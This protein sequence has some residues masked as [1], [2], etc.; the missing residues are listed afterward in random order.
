MLET[1]KESIRLLIAGVR[2]KTI[3]KLYIAGNNMEIIKGNLL[4]SNE[5]T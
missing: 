3:E 4:Y 2:G 1:A 5:V